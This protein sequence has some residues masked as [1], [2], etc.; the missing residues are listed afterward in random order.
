MQDLVLIMKS[1]PSLIDANPPARV[2]AY[3]LRWTPM[4]IFPYLKWKSEYVS[5]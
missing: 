1:C 3:I 5:P 2:A 4:P